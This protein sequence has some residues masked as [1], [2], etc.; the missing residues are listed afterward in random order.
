MKKLLIIIL[1]IFLFACENN[2]NTYK[3]KK[4]YHIVKK[5]ETFEDNHKLS[6]Y[7]LDANDNY[8]Y[9]DRKIEIVDTVGK[10]NTGDSIFLEAHKK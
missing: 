3:H 10:F 2:I 1:P 5:I 4:I 8:F 9:Y 6:R 7:F